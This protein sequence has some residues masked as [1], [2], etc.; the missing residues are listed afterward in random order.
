MDN[1]MKP[2]IFTDPDDLPTT[3]DMRDLDERIISPQA[4]TLFNPKSMK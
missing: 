3:E 2:S 4:V 1:G